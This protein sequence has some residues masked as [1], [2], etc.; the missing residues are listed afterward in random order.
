MRAMLIRL[1]YASR[2]RP[3]VSPVDLKDIIRASQRNN[4]AVGVTGALLLSSGVFL[5][6]LEGDLLVVNA[7]YHRILL[8]A[9]HH[10]PAILDF[11]EIDARRFGDWS[12]GLVT[13]TEDNR[14]IFLKYS[15]TAEFNPFAMRP[16]ALRGLFVE[17]Q[18]QARRVEA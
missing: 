10:E 6:C 17:L 14:R 8:D 12:M 2:A 3:T 1:T 9:R 13:L 18:G 7:L 16:S 5:Q 4:A 15:P 11:E